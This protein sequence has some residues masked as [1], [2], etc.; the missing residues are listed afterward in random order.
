MKCLLLLDLSMLFFTAKALRSTISYPALVAY[1][2]KCV[3]AEEGPEVGVSFQVHGFTARSTA[4][5]AQTAFLDSLEALG[6][7]VHSFAAS[8]AHF[9]ADMLLQVA[10]HEADRAVLV[11]ND[12]DAVRVLRECMHAEHEESLYLSLA[13]FAKDLV[14]PLKQAIQQDEFDFIDLGLEELLTPR[15]NTRRH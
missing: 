13:Y 4:N 11:T 3:Q 9:L 1:L 14:E 12:P 7:Q 6:V 10:L 2:K 15:P 5:A 8:D